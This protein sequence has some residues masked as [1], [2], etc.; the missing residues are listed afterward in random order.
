[1]AHFLGDKFVHH[2]LDCHGQKVALNQ[3]LQDDHNENFKELERQ[4]AVNNWTFSLSEK[5]GKAHA[6]T[7]NS[8]EKQNKIEIRSAFRT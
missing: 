3:E 1:M 7:Q 4:N 8:G 2:T 5:S 6:N